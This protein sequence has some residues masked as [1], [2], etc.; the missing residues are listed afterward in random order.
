LCHEDE[1]CRLPG[2]STFARRIWAG[3]EEQRL[4]LIKMEIVW[5]KIFVEFCNDRMAALSEMEVIGV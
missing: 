5:Y 4:A 1:E 2:V 3:Q